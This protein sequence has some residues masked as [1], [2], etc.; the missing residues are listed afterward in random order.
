MAAGLRG[1]NWWTPRHCGATRPGFISP[2]MW[3]WASEQMKREVHN[4][5]P[6]ARVY[7]RTQRRKRCPAEQLPQRARDRAAAA[8]FAPPSSGGGSFND[9][10][11][12][13]PGKPQKS[14]LVSATCLSW[15][16][17]TNHDLDDLVTAAPCS[18]VS[19]SEL[20]TLFRSE[21]PS[22]RQ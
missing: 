16:A 2:E 7:Q 22:T 20:T 1:T 19:D 17:S 21:N 11:Q 15:F 18:M 13:V 6:A 8:T 12:S 14:P 3:R 4:T 10:S 9:S 5:D